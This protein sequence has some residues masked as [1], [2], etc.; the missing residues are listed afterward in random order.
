VR[1][2][3]EEILIPLLGAHM[4]FRSRTVGRSSVVQGSMGACCFTL[5]LREATLAVGYARSSQFVSCQDCQYL[6][7]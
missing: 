1:R 3:T 4:P 6:D 5:S 2:R 7:S